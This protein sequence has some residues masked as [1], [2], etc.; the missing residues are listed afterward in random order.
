[1]VALLSLAVTGF[2]FFRPSGNRLRLSQ[3]LTALTLA[4]GTWLVLT[5]NVSLLRVCAVGLIY[6]AIVVYGIVLARER[7]LSQEASAA[8]KN[9][10]E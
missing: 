9:H 7:L 10:T 4:S 2:T 6:T 8:L 5:L 1:M 3:A